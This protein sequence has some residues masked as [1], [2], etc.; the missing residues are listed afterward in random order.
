[1]ANRDLEEVLRIKPDFSIEAYAK[2]NPFRDP[3]LVEY[4]KE[5]LREA[6]LK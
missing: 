3:A 4:R 5:L 1:V 2:A 6:G